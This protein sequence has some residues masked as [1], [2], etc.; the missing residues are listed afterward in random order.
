[1]AFSIASVDII[2]QQAAGN[3]NFAGAFLALF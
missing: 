3:D 2:L 1:M